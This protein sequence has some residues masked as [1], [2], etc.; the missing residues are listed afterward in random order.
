MQT[1][2]MKLSLWLVAAVVMN[3]V[4]RADDPG[5]ADKTAADEILETM[6]R[7][8][9]L[10]RLEFAD[11]D[12]PQ[13]LSL[14]DQPILRYGDPTRIDEDGTVWI[15]THDKRP[16][17]VLAFWL[18]RPPAAKWTYELTSLTDR[19][20]KMVGRPTLLWQPQEQQRKWIE[21]EQKVPDTPA[22]RL[23]TLRALAR[24]FEAT[25]TFEG[26]TYSLRLVPTPL[27]RYADQGSA[28][29][30]GALFSMA[31]GTNPEILLQIEARTDAEGSPH[32]FASIGRMSGALLEIRY[33]DETE[34][35]AEPIGPF[36]HDSTAPYFSTWTNSD[37]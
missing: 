20:L 33:S 22:A 19:P 26:Q 28:V 32:W 31:N 30:D 25:E 36:E 8:A 5:P 21:L 15:W 2:I 7:A 6:T 9:K 3:S 4:C 27:Y 18:G 12:D 37:P 11:E 16:V 29:V 17:A 24:R 1:T 34:W 35:T 14:I 13:P 23:T 10:L